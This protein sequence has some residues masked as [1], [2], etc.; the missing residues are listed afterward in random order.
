[1][2]EWVKDLQGI[3]GAIG[4]LVAVVFGALYG[5]N[6]AEL[7]RKDR[8]IKSYAD[9]N[10]GLEEVIKTR[11]LQHDENQKRILVLEQKANILENQVTQAPSINKLALQMGTQ[12]KEMMTQL[13]KL[14]KELGGIAK[15]MVRER[16]D[17]DQ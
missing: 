14:T 3:I 4:F 7:D 17:A 6:K 16:Q 2:P 9:A 1:M 5:R 13:S 12:H 8:T 10:A 15:A 11:D